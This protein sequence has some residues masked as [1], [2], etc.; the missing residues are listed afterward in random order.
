MP[1]VTTPQGRQA[2][3]PGVYSGFDVVSDLPGALPEF[4]V[5]IVVSEAE[6][7]YPADVRASQLAHENLSPWKLRG[8]SSSVKEWFGRDSDMAVAYA[9]AKKHGLP[10]AY[11]VA[12]NSL[13]RQSV[14]ATST[15][16]INQMT[17]YAQKY[18][19]PP[20]Y[21]KLRFSGGILEAT[22]LAN[23]SRLTANAAIGATRIYVRDNSW[24]QV[25]S[26]ITL[27]A[28]NVT[29][30]TK[31]VS[32]IGTELDPTTG[33]VLYWIEVTVALAS[34]ITTA[35][36]ALICEYDDNSKETSPAFSAGEGQLLLD[37]LQNESEY[38]N[39]LKHAAFTGALPITIGT[40]TALKDISTWSTNTPGTTPAATSTDHTDFITDLDASEW[41]Q[42][43]LET[44]SIAQAFLIVDGSSTIHASWRDF[45]VAKRTEG[46]AISVTT[47][48]RWG[49]VEIGAGNDTDPLF[50]L[51]ALNSQDVCLAIG[52]ID[53]QDAYLSLAPA[54]FG[55][56]I[57]KGIPHNLTNDD[58]FYTEL[59]V[60]W[61][62]RNSG[63][64]TALHKAGALT[65]RLS[66]QSSIRYRISE[67]LN[68]LQANDN[69]WNETTD[70]TCLIMQRDLA[71]FVDRVL[72][73]DLDEKQVGQERVTADT[74]AAV[75]IRRAEKSLLRRGLI[76]DFAIT[77][78][79][80]NESGTGFDVR[81]TVRLPVT[82][83]FIT[84][85]T[86][87][88]IGEE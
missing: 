22:P 21:I 10:Q 76:T 87:I 41:D 9:A 53:R 27:G 54:A 73:L 43:A 71:D 18:G 3:V 30:F 86:T 75:V 12:I 64:L 14:I 63:E 1:S 44:Q 84:M 13:T 65:Y 15:G 70:D 34:A 88:L 78:I 59:E 38:L 11:C 2:F 85:V 66:V 5:P 26:T 50:R 35:Q 6:E 47:G 32:A 24:V 67:G 57:E 31:V 60:Q 51:A 19:A 45:A 16:P 74:V 81:W 20:N 46:Y 79:T 80:L 56:R 55:R 36:Y 7:G 48:A 42:F 39:G 17:V 8:T 52:G 4:Q 29:A 68:T 40:A 72:K 37:W 62:E 83:D 77:S 61:D 25:D 23:F 82:T 58:L 33:Q 69:S 28:N 49:D